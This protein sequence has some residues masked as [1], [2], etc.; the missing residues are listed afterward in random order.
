MP[1]LGRHPITQLE[2]AVQASLSDI[3][4]AEARLRS[5]YEELAR[6]SDKQRPGIAQG[7]ARL[8]YR[9]W[10]DE[11]RTQ[12][13]GDEN[14]PAARLLDRLVWSPGSWLVSDLRGGGGA[15]GPFAPELADL[16]QAA[17]FLDLAR[18]E[19]K[20]WRSRVLF[21]TYVKNVPDEGQLVWADVRAI[22]VDFPTATATATATLK[23]FSGRAV[24]IAPWSRYMPL[25]VEEEST[26]TSK[27]RKHFEDLQNSLVGA[28][29]SL[30]PGPD[31]PGVD[32]GKYLYLIELRALAPLDIPGQ[33]ADPDLLLA[34]LTPESFEI[35]GP[36]LGLAVALTAWAGQRRRSLVPLIATGTIDAQGVVGP[37]GGISQKAIAVRDFAGGS[38][39]FLTPALTPIESRQLENLGVRVSSGEKLSAFVH[40]DYLTDGFDGFRDL[41]G[42][43]TVSESVLK[44]LDVVPDDG[45]AP[46]GYS[47][48]DRTELE[49][50]AK[51]L[52]TILKSRPVESPPHHESF[53]VFTVPFDEEPGEAALALTGCITGD[54]WWRSKKGEWGELP[55]VLP[56][57]LALLGKDSKSSAN[58]SHT[59]TSSNLPERVAAAIPRELKP[60]N[61]L[62]RITE[63]HIE[64]ALKSPGKLILVVYDARSLVL[65]PRIQ[66][67]PERYTANLGVL[68]SLATDPGA[69]N[70]RWKPQCMIAVCSDYHHEQLWKGTAEHRT[71][72]RSTGT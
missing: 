25:R 15:F 42:L 28:L 55:V 16:T 30:P 61:P 62:L 52:L 60:R 23:E 46:T 72:R 27:T 1:D 63:G 71:T 33:T 2:Q 18:D 4:A 20:S 14:S 13:A 68:R 12:A 6:R 40:N 8:L 22:T 11:R 34:R 31:A 50:T 7:V 70:L 36:S 29:E 32:P 21:P 45:A 17:R 39:P 24:L 43:G 9:F 59:L 48:S 49:L 5:H 41:I 53:F 69:A 37:V 47:Q 65:W 26:S 54:E 58:H 38:I 44:P 35:G 64:N 19:S 10:R 67:D 3:T 56:I 51:H 57:H 66:E